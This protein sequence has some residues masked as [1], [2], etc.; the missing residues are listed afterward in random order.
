VTLDGVKLSVNGGAVRVEGPP[1]RQDWTVHVIVLAPQDARLDLETRNGPLGVQDVSGRVVARA[2][3]GP[4]GIKGCS[5]EIRIDAQNG[6]VDISG[7]SGDVRAVANNGPLSI[8]LS[9]QS[10]DGVGLQGLANNG[11]LSLKVPDGYQSGVQVEMSRS[12]PL[13]C[14]APMCS[15][16]VRL[17]GEDGGTLRIGSNDPQVRLSAHNG[18]VSISTSRE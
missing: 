17:G 4:I 18:P 2:S 13:Q 14:R 12:S 8:H 5:G 3:N 11:P 10:W 6:P 7:T 15:D 9:G 16:A 1:D